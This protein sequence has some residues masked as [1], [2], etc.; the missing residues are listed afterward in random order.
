MTSAT[1]TS[2]DAVTTTQAIDFTGSNNSY[3]ATLSVPIHNDAVGE[4]TG[5]IEVTL[6]RNDIATETYKRCNRW[7]ANGYRDYFG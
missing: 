7:N 4:R 3:T 2:Q 5:Q 1:P 6:L